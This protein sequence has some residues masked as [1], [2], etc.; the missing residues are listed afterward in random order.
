MDTGSWQQCLPAAPTGYTD[1]GMIVS[2]TGA[3]DVKISSDGG[4]N[5]V[6]ITAGA[7]NVGIP[8]PFAH[9]GEIVAQ[10]FGGSTTITLTLV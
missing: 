8:G 3:N 5:S 10:A 7:L 6:R 1:Q 9:R 4:H 2:N